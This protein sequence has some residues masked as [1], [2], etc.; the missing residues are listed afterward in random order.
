MNILVTGGLGFLGFHIGGGTVRLYAGTK[1]R[2]PR[3]LS[4]LG[5]EW[6]HRI[7]FEPATRAR[8][9]AGGLEFAA[10]LLQAAVLRRRARRLA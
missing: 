9:L 2:A 8:Y 7:T 10:N 4:R 3:W 6:A 1:R 5:L